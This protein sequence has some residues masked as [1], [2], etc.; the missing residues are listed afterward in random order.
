MFMHICLHKDD[1]FILW[2]LNNRADFV[3][4]SFFGV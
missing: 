3:V 2:E 1:V 4:Q